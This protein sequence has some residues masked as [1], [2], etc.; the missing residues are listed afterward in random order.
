MSTSQ[1]ISVVTANVNKKYFNKNIEFISSRSNF[2]NSKIRLVKSF[3][4]FIFFIQK[5]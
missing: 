1:N 3:F 2:Y 4:V 5:L